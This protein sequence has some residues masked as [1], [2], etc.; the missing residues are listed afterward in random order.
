VGRGCVSGS[1]SERGR[2]S[3]LSIVALAE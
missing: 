2:S 1:W 3:V